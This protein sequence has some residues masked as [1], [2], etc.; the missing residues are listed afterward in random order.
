MTCPC[1][2][3]LTPAPVAPGLTFGLW[4]ATAELTVP[5]SGA[6]GLFV[7]TSSNTVA[8]AKALAGWALTAAG[9]LLTYT[10]PTAS[11]YVQLVCSLNTN[12]ASGG[13]QT[14]DQ[15]LSYNGNMI[16]VGPGA[17]FTQGEVRQLQNDVNRSENLTSVWVFQ[18]VQSGDTIRPAWAWSVNNNTLFV[19][20]GY[21]LL[22]PCS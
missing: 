18:N 3:P 19:R 4:H 20:R 16:G 5:T 13:N 22:A 8:E 21:L 15:V 1:C 9:W 17:V 2:S 14:A 12:G 6:G 11:F 10:G 7:A